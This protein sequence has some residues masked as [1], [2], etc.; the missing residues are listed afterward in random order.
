MATG[1][2]SFQSRLLLGAFQMD[3]PLFL[4]LQHPKT[5]SQL[6]SVRIKRPWLAEAKLISITYQLT[7]LFEPQ[8]PY[9]YRGI[10]AAT[11]WGCGMQKEGP[12]TQPGSHLG[13]KGWSMLTWGEQLAEGEG[14]D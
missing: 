10:R 7:G 14:G 3:L 9:L 4:F 2:Q 1:G 8:F 5:L 13:S 11:S 12:W 6:C